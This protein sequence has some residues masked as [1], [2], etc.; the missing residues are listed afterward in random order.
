MQFLDPCTN[1]SNLEKPQHNHTT[2]TTTHIGSNTTMK[3]E[4]TTVFTLPG[5]WPASRLSSRGKG[6]QPIYS[7]RNK[8]TNSGGIVN[9]LPAFLGAAYNRSSLKFLT[10]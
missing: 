4:D 10:L 1:I 3:E 5:V 6:I 7:L 2:N 8:S 9:V